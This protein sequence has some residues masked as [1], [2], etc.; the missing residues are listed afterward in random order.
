MNKQILKE[1]KRAYC[2]STMEWGK[3]TKLRNLDFRASAPVSVNDA[4]KIMRESLGLKSDTEEGYNNF[5][6]ALLR[7]LPVGSKVTLAR[8]GSVCVYVTLPK[9][10]LFC[11]T[12]A[13]EMKADEFHATADGFRL[14]WD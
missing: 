2:D 6:P 12:S 9:D 1:T 8:E 4:V 14:W 11:E 7:R 3:A 13:K 10:A 5:A